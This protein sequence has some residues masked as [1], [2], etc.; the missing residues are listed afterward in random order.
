MGDWWRVE[1][2][3]HLGVLCLERLGYA[4]DLSKIAQPKRRHRHRHHTIKST[5]ETTQERTKS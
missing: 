4:N 5:D 3:V 1:W 2:E